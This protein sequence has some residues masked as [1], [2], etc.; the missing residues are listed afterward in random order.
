[1]A[2][3]DLSPRPH[4]LIGELLALLPLPET[5]WEAEDRALWLQTVANA[6]AMIYRGGPPAI[7]VKAVRPPPPVNETPGVVTH[8]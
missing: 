4:P 7:T 3:T 5:R 8:G 1:M 2:E 6:F